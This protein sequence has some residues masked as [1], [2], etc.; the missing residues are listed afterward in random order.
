MPALPH[1]RVLGFSFWWD[2]FLTSCCWSSR[3]HAGEAG[4]R[5]HRAL[6]KRGRWLLWLLCVCWF[7]SSSF[8]SFF[9]C[10]RR[11]SSSSIS[12][13]GGRI[14]VRGWYSVPSFPR[15]RQLPLEGSH[16]L[17][18]TV[19]CRQEVRTRHARD[20]SY[21]LAP[22]SIQH[23]AAQHGTA[24]YQQ[25]NSGDRPAEPRRRARISRKVPGAGKDMGLALAARL[26][27][28]T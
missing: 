23:I 4:G 13:S 18:T 24:Q 20:T 25:L 6:E 16:Y 7:F 2:W 10:F 21:L 15:A 26:R 28:F 11:W 1:A 9:V 22:H 19:L 12:L 17:Y 3:Q 27:S 5:G 14:N 8:F